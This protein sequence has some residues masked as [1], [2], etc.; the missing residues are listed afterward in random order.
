[1]GTIVAYNLLLLSL[2]SM[3]LV[4]Q[5]RNRTRCSV[6]LTA[7]L[8][9]GIALLGTVGAL[10][11]SD[12]VFCSAQ[13]LAWTAFVHYPVFLAGTAACLYQRRP[14]LACLSAT[15]SAAMLLIGLDAFLIEP[16]WL[17]VSRAT[18][19]SEKLSSR[20][21]VAVIADLQTDAPGAYERGVLRQAMDEKPDMILM[22]G[23]YVQARDLGRYAELCNAM[24]AIMHEVGLRAPLGTY[25]VG[26]NVDRAGVWPLI[27]TGG[28]V[29]FER[30]SS[31]DLG[32]V[33]LTGLTHADSTD[34]TL[35]VAARPQFHIVL[36][37]SPNF[38]LGDVNADLLIAGH[39]HGGQ[40]RLP[41]I[42]PGLTLSRIPRP[43]AAGVTALAP[44]KVLVVSR[45]IGMERGLAPRMRFLCRPELVI[46]EL[47]PTRRA[48]GHDDTQGRGDHAG[49]QFRQTIG[50][51][52][53][54][55]ADFVPHARQRAHESLGEVDTLDL[56]AQWR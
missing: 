48:S 18:V 31:V 8:A 2:V 32:Q 34:T 47:L 41:M 36:G 56:R 4:P 13:L 7:S 33:V 15:T 20:I 29:V 9:L 10:C 44:G 27:S 37:H 12:D 17:E 38:A 54:T 21:R 23:D 35:H 24:N 55:P 50:P 5:W 28:V 40:V 6:L 49:V 11:G 19:S 39:T 16:H 3:S 14:L 43:W 25:A 51:V 46:L 45:G 26:G 30:T 52:E 1:M 22:A 42:G 53:P